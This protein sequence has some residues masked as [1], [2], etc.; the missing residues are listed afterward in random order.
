MKT[1]PEVMAFFTAECELIHAICDKHMV[2]REIDT[3][4]LTMAQRVTVLGEVLA[5]MVQRI[6]HPPL[7]TTH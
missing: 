3:M 6:G 7:N 1:S 5:G 4:P 2:P